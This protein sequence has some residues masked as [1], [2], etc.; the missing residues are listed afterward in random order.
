LGLAVLEV[1]LA[2]LFFAIAYNNYKKTGS[3]HCEKQKDEEDTP[4]K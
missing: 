3:I 4:N 2:L 1:A